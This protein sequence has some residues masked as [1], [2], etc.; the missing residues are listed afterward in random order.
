MSAE[1]S[2]LRR[3]GEHLAAGLLVAAPI[4]ALVT[5]AASSSFTDPLTITLTVTAAATVIAFIRTYIVLA[6][7]ERTPHSR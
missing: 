6:L 5:Y 1:K 3:T 4:N 2:R 7:H